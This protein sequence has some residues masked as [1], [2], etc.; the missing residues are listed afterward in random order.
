MQAFRVSALLFFVSLV[1][2]PLQAQ[3][4]PLTPGRLTTELIPEVRAARLFNGAAGFYLDIPEGAIRVEIELTTAPPEAN[5]NLYGRYDVDVEGDEENNI[6]ADIR[7]EN[8]GGSERLLLTESTPVALRPGRLFIALSAG[9]RNPQTFAFLKTAVEMTP[10]AGDLLTIASTNFETGTP[11]GW[12]RNYPEPS[13]VVPGATLGSAQATM[14]A[15]RGPLGLSRNLQLTSRGEDYFVAPAEYLGKLRLLGP[16]PRLE[17]DLGVLGSEIPTQAAEV[18]LIGPFTTWRWTGPVPSNRSSRYIVPIEA[19][20]WERISGSATFAETL[21]NVLRLEIRGSHGE[22][23]MVTFLDNVALLGKAE[24]PSTPLRSTFDTT[25]EGWRPNFP[26]APFLIPRILGVTQ[27]DF[28]TASNG[29]RILQTGGNP[30]GFLQVRDLDDVNR[31]AVVAPDSFLGDWAALGSEARLEFDRRHDSNNGATR[32]V[33][34]R[35]LGFGG[36]YL[37]SGA[38]PGRNWTR[39]SVPLQADQWVSIDGDRTFAEVLR[40][41]QRLE[42]TMDE[43]VGPEDSGIDNVSLIV[44]PPIVPQLSAAP[45]SLV[46]STTQGAVRPEAKVISI[47]SNGPVLEWIAAASAGAS[48]IRLPDPRG[49]TPDELAV[50]V[51]PSGLSAGVHRGS[52]EIAWEGSTRTV[53]IP[54]TLNI[55][56]ATGPLLSEGGVVNAA[57]FASNSAPGGEL[58]GGMYFAAFG[59]RLADRTVQASA[60]PLPTELGGVTVSIGGI[61]AP[62]V[63][64]SANQIVGVIPQGLTQGQQTPQGISEADA[65]VIRNGEVSAP[66]RIRLAPLRPVLFSQDETGSGPGA[67]LNLAGSTVQLNTFDTPARP[68]QAVSLYGSGFGPTQTFVPD[69]TGSSGANPVTAAVRVRVGGR[70][71]EVLF[72]GLSVSP[73]LY[74]ANIILPAD[75]EQ[76]CEVPV[77]ILVDGVASN[78]VTIALTDDGRSCR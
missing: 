55:V 8:P 66:E 75:S 7:S 76:G 34:V 45:T 42:I 25:P 77:Q 19:S 29:F 60:V 41:V 26:D 58:T 20:A 35:I 31:D 50:M 2:A 46:F 30:G 24:A 65:I 74:Q 12:T 5:I 3:P 13:P 39:Y 18:R 69:G 14:A 6:F 64:V 73:H 61:P 40:A 43:V 72:A 44:P 9:F 4:R 68:T 51:E 57:T 67:V 11:E 47:T 10:G 54:V 78:T 28:R 49:V 62:L 63:F 56:S 16:S 52:V 48:W 37:W 32:G 33:E 21:D 15:V 36:A 1:A 17:F 70:D 22:P 27:G 71:A 38:V 53:S 23:G 59:L